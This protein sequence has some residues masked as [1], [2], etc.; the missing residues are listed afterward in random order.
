MSN[1]DEAA[2]VTWL[3]MDEMQAVSPHHA[4]IEH[5]KSRTFESVR[6]ALIFVMEELSAPNR[7]SAMI[8]A[9]TREIQMP[10]IEVLY[11]QIKKS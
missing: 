2:K 6:N 5:S 8:H 9:D 10:E 11:S 4:K 1:L 7:T 3:V